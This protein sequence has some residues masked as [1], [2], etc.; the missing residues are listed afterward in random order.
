MESRIIKRAQSS[1][2]MRD[3]TSQ[4]KLNERDFGDST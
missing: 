3:P 4:N 1:R 2:Q